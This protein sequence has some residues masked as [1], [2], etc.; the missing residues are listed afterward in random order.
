MEPTNNIFKTLL[1]SPYTLRIL[2][3]IYKG[4]R[5]S[6]IAESLDISQQNV[7]YYTNQLI[8]AKLIEKLSTEHGLVWKL[9][10]RGQFILK[11]ILSRSVNISNSNNNT[12][13]TQQH[14]TIPIRM[15]NVTF[16]FDILSGIEENIRLRWKPINNG[17]SKCFIKYPDHTLELTKSQNEIESVLEVHL[18]ELYTFDLYQGL[19][20]QYD[21]AR[22]YASLAAQRLR[23]IISVNGRL[24]K[25]PHLAFEHD[26]IAMYLATFQTA[27]TM[28]G[29]EGRKAKAWI[30]SSKGNGELETNDIN[31]AYKYLMMPEIVMEIQKA[32]NKMARQT[33]RYERHYH[34]I[35]SDNN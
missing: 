5:P 14:N 9:T 21:I 3:N 11:Q 2:W 25:K 18:T 27:E 23:L 28:T 13:N 6:Q 4:Y 15:H 22:D 34:P 1:K 33:A 31:Y 19:L 8:A 17:V 12:P 10:E 26:L 29:R 32:V 20:K 7:Y 35:T 30:D 16:S 24:V